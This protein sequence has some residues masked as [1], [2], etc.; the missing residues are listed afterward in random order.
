MFLQCKPQKRELSFVA[1][2]ATLKPTANQAGV[3]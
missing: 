3:M 2:G 1:D